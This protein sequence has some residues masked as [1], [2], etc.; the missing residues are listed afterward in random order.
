MLGILWMHSS[1]PGYDLATDKVAYVVSTSRLD[2]QWQWTMDST[3]QT[4]LPGTVR[5]NFAHFRK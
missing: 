1:A 2:D 4:Y 5:G 3:I